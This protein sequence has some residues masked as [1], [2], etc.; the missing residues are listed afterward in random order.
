MRTLTLHIGWPKTGTSSLQALLAHN[1]DWLRSQGVL[2]PTVERWDNTHHRVCDLLITHNDPLIPPPEGDLDQLLDHLDRPENRSAEHVIL[3]SEG[4]CRALV[5]KPAAAQLLQNRFRIRVLA[6]LREP[7]FWAN[8]LLNEFAKSRLILE[9]TV[10]LAE[11]GRQMISRDIYYPA[12]L[13]PWAEAFGRES[14]EVVTLNEG[15]DYLTS[16]LAALGL[17]RER[18]IA[19][20]GDGRNQSLGLGSLQLIG[21]LSRTGRLPDH[22]GRIA[23]DARLRSYPAGRA[24]NLLAPAVEQLVQTATPSISAALSRDWLGRR[25]AFANERVLPA[26]RS[27]DALDS[28]DLIEIVRYAFPKK[29][30]FHAALARDIA[31]H[32]GRSRK[33][34]W[35]RLFPRRG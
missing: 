21:W 30:D 1:A 6:C 29:R 10:D 32:G 15:A 24:P 12:R 34:F 28:P 25:Q 27:A 13:E 17:D 4:F 19:P 8:S 35:R 23:L 11:L 14:V 18:L 7:I 9:G 16:I 5:I 33:T 22:A 31:E 20:P 3:S 2:Y 26:Y